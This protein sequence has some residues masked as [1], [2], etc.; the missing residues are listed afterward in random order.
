MLDDFCEAIEALPFPG[1]GERSHPEE[2]TVRAARAI[3][4]DAVLDDNFLADC[5][6]HEFALIRSNQIRQ[7]LTRFL[8]LPQSGIGLAFGYWPPGG[9]PGPHEHTA[10]TISAVC[11][12]ELQIVT[13]DREETLR[14]RELVPGRQLRA[15]SGM[16]GYV[17][18]PCI[19]A[20]KNASAEWTLSMHLI[21][22]RDGEPLPDQTDAIPGLGIPGQSLPSSHQR[23]PYRYVMLA[24]QRIWY[25]LP[26]ARVLAGLNSPNA[27][28][29][30]R[31]CHKA[32]SSS[33]RR[34]LTRMSPHMPKEERRTSPYLLERVHPDLVLDYA[35]QNGLVT[36]SADTANG[37]REEIAINDI[38]RDA[39]AFAAKSRQFDIRDLPGP[40]TDEER[41][42]IGELLEDAGL[43]TRKY[44]D[45]GFTH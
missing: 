35:Y 6:A 11:R 28:A 23:H 43:F 29:L 25:A 14:R 32:A 39:I 42:A 9:S 41:W 33:T 2:A 30:L 44:Q 19:H 38:A 5:F 17:H 12:N 15:Q 20:P 4:A 13:F 8:T 31:E 37:P 26:L 34:R 21:S 24:R 16:V 45:G 18:V 36:L 10:W 22:P 3:V 27:R 7:G 1:S 40:L